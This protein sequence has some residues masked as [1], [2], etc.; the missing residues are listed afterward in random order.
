MNTCNVFNSKVLNEFYTALFCTSYRD[1]ACA[2]ES[3]KTDEL[4]DYD[5][6][7]D[8]FDNLICTFLCEDLDFEVAY[9]DVI[10]ALKAEPRFVEHMKAEYEELLELCS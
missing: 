6:F 5:N 4:F 10:L 3:A 2:T 9:N 7:E 1:H 8:W